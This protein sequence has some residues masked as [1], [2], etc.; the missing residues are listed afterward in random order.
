MY[1][2]KIRHRESFGTAAGSAWRLLFVDA[3]MPWLKKNR[4]QDA[5]VCHVEAPNGLD[6]RKFA[7]EVI[8]G[9]IATNI[10]RN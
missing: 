9:V 6:I 2:M 5:F 3:L 8:G 4:I 1:L 10:A 7:N